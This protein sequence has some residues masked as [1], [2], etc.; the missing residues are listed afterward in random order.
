MGK[1]SRSRKNGREWE[2]KV[3]S[4]R[5]RRRSEERRQVVGVDRK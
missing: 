1:G 5:I 2:M 4:S 3:S